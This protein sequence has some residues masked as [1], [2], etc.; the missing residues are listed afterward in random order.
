MSIS[1]LK[2][3]MMSGRLWSVLL[4]FSCFPCLPLKHSQCKSLWTCAFWTLKGSAH[5]TTATRLPLTCI[6]VRWHHQIIH[7]NSNHAHR[8]WMPLLQGM[9]HMQRNRVSCAFLSIPKWIWDSKTWCCQCVFQ[10]SAACAPR[11]SEFE[12]NSLLHVGKKAQETKIN[13]WIL[14]RRQGKSNLAWWGSGSKQK[15]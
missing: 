9:H 1:G 5:C 6:T 13:S 14:W 7:A 10:F 11:A 2:Y 8:V 12:G 3:S 4:M 15:S